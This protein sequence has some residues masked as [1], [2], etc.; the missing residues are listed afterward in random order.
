MLQQWLNRKKKRFVCSY[1]II[2]ELDISVKLIKIRHHKYLEITVTLYMVAR[3]YTG[4]T[5][6][7]ACIVY[8]A[9]VCWQFHTLYWKNIWEP[10]G[11]RVI[12]ESALYRTA[13]KWSPRYIGP[14][15][16]GVRVIL[17]RVIMESQCTLYFICTQSSAEHGHCQIKLWSSSSCGMIEKRKICNRFQ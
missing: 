15:Y 2:P 7:T 14:C 12:M 5:I 6:F 11:D 1:L 13:L 8:T 4:N 10:R 9:I 16:N 17:D 3:K